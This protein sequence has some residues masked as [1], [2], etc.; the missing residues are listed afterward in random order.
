MASMQKIGT[1]MTDILFFIYNN[2]YSTYLM[3]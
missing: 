3:E 2:Q 1:V